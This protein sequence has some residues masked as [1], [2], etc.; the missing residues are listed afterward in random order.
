MVLSTEE[1]RESI[2]M[3]AVVGGGS[4]GTAGEESWSKETSWEGTVVGAWRGDGGDPGLG[5]K[6]WM[7]SGDS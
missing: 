3:V 2:Q 4:G 5:D 1:W 7:I 6:K